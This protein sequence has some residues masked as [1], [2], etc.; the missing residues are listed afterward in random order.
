MKRP[1]SVTIIAWILIV[2]ACMGLP[3]LVIFSRRRLS[4]DSVIFILATAI[5][6]VSGI[7]ILKGLNWGRLL[8]LFYIPIAYAWGLIVFAFS[9]SGRFSEITTDSMVKLNFIKL[10]PETIFY[11]VAFVY[12]TRPAASAFFARRKLEGK[13]DEGKDGEIR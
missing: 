1:R 11:I 10:I 6:I 4:G 3:S 13:H 5:I 7:A 2:R 9:F 8:Y 12:L